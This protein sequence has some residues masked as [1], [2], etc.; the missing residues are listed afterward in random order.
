MGLIHPVGA[1]QNARDARAGGFSED[2]AGDGGVQQIAFGGQ[3][4]EAHV[5]FRE[6]WGGPFEVIENQV[7]LFIVTVVLVRAERLQKIGR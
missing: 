1:R 7:V 6:L 4:G 2:H 5:E 3:A